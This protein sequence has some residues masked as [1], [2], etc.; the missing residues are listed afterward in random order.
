MI[1]LSLV[2]STNVDSLLSEMHT[3]SVSDNEWGLHL[4]DLTSYHNLYSSNAR[5]SLQT[6][7]P[8]TQG[9]K[10]IP[11]SVDANVAASAWLLQYPNWTHVQPA[12]ITEAFGIKNTSASDGWY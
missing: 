11:V 10:R 6:S 2:S 4:L 8:D 3:A 12:H 5:T 7:Y 1:P 9:A